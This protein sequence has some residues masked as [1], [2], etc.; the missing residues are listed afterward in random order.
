VAKGS[1]VSRAG[2]ELA[3]DSFVANLRRLQDAALVG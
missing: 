1:V 3:E 2:V